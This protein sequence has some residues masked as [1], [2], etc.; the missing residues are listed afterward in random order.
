MIRGLIYGLCLAVLWVG[1]AST[2]EV[3]IKA[4]DREQGYVYFSLSSLSP[5]DVEVAAIV[6]IEIGDVFWELRTDGV[7]ESNGMLNASIHD[8]LLDYARFWEAIHEISLQQ[9][10]GAPK[11]EGGE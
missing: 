3:P 7:V 9:C 2:D 4:D 10:E 11:R 1:G 5:C 8:A 6:R